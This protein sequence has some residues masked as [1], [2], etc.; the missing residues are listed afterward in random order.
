MRLLFRK[1]RVSQE[2]NAGISMDV[3]EDEVESF[4]RWLAAS[5]VPWLNNFLVAALVYEVG[6]SSLRCGDGVMMDVTTVVTGFLHGIA[7]KYNYLATAI[8][9]L[10]TVGYLDCELA[11]AAAEHSN[12]SSG[13]TST[14]SSNSAA[15]EDARINAKLDEHDF[16]SP[17]AF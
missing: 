4:L 11:A 14:S 6:A 8:Q 15:S 16:R 2:N 7:N 1:F 17:D 12:S 13:T 5:D 10:S 9:A 3:E